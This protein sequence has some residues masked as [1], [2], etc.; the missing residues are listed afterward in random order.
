VRL[1]GL[2][3]LKKKINDLIG[4]QT[5]AQYD[6][7]VKRSKQTLQRKLDNAMFIMAKCEVSRKMTASL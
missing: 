4:N 2:G 5:H 3:Q 6:P 7:A 1:E